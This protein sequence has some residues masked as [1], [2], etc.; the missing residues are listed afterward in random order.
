[1]STVGVIATIPWAIALMPFV[2]IFQDWWKQLVTI[3][4]GLLVMQVV[5]LG[6]YMVE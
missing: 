4:V 6:F 2:I 3:Q 5:A 1:M